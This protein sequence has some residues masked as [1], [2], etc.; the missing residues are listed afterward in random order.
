[1][2]SL[3]IDASLETLS[4]ALKTYGEDELAQRILLIDEDTRKKIGEKAWDYFSESRLLAYVLTRA[5]IAILE[6]RDRKP[7]WKKRKLKGIY[8]GM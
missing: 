2:A 4:L 1:M 3:V 5:T 8:P 6:G 7:K